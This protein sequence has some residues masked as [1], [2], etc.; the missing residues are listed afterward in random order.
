MVDD[1]HAVET[2]RSKV[3]NRCLWAQLRQCCKAV[4]AL[5]CHAL[6]LVTLGVTG[7][8]RLARNAV[9]LGRLVFAGSKKRLEI[10]PVQWYIIRVPSV[11]TG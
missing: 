1:S 10:I 6:S 9:G 8:E 11:E 7:R 5:A 3:G 2:F 4:I